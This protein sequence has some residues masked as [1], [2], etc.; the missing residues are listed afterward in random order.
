MSIEN[1]VNCPN[2]MGEG[3]ML[4]A[5]HPKTSDRI[6]MCDKCK[7]IWETRDFE[8]NTKCYSYDTFWLKTNRKE[9]DYM[10]WEY[11]IK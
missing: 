3:K 6:Y 8:D 2:C 11:I 5:V 7:D 9:S 10:S 4:T 1:R